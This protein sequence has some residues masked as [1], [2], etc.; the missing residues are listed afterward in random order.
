MKHIL[1]IA[2]AA[3]VAL[4][5][6]AR[7]DIEYVVVITVDG[8]RGA[9]IQ[10]L[11]ANT[12]DFPNFN[13]FKNA[14][15][16]TFN[17]RCD[18]THSV[19]IPDHLTMVT[20]RP[21]QNPGGQPATT[22][23]GYTSDAPAAT[24]TIHTYPASGGN[25][26]G[27]YKASIFDVVHDRGFSTACYI[28]KN[29]LQILPRSYDAT[30]GAADVTGAD[31]G[32]NKIT[33]LMQGEGQPTDYTP[34][35]SAT[36]ALH[37]AAASAVNPGGLEK[38]SFLHIAET[39][40][41][42]HSGNWNATVGSA[43]YNKMKTADGWIGTIL[44]AINNN[45]WLAD[46]VAVLLTADHGG[47]GG[48]VLT[49]HQIATA[50]ENATIPFFVRAP[51]FAPGSDLYS[52]FKNRFDPKATI[53]EYV[54]TPQ[55]IRNA[56]IANLSAALLGL[57]AVPGSSAIPELMDNLRISKSAD[58]SVSL[59]WP[60]Y[61]TGYVLEEA[62]VVDGWWRKVNT[63]ITVANQQ[64]TRTYATPYTSTHFYRLRKPGG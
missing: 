24:D 53:P 33:T 61:L 38:F 13:A 44:N 23:H 40:Y 63:G 27:F 42:G 52:Y 39:D 14:A 20:G 10:G 8:C 7:A 36:L 29:R 6:S 60:A 16:T 51:G 48:S 25:N 12:A 35:T 17:A 22:S 15:A 59:A 9:F 47:G 43:Y 31:N 28:S 34:S 2:G 64:K 58:D 55:P 19:T 49:H 5:S 21:V 45:A 57:P 30:N 50:V 62:V 3:L 26:S 37:I 41:A 32:K 4:A 56:D 11:M 54:N 18:K 1:S 46:K